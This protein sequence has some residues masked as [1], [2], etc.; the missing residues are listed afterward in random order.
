M[1]KQSF[2]D[3]WFDIVDVKEREDGSADITIDVSDDFIT[4]YKLK[5]GKKR[6]TKKGVSKYI[7][8]HLSS[9]LIKKIEK[10]V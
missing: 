5:T 2:D 1:E 7:E 3:S 4:A 10:K 8:D 9:S 6:A